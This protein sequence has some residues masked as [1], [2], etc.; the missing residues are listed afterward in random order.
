MTPVHMYFPL[1]EWFQQ[2]QQHINLDRHFESPIGYKVAVFWNPPRV[3]IP[4]IC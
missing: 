2:S 4:F 3:L 1:E